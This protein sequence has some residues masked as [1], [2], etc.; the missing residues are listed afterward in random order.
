MCDG[1][2]VVV[3]PLGAADFAAADTVIRGLD[4]AEF[5]LADLQRA[6]AGTADAGTAMH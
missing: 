2:D 3:R 1:S 6:V 5:I 4:T